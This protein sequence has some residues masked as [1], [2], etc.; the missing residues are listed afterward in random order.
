MKEREGV[1]LEGRGGQ[2]EVEGAEGGGMI[3]RT[4]CI[5]KEHFQ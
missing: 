4:Y 2:E 1:G 3:V 5:R